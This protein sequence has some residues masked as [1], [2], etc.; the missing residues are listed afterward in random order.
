MQSLINKGMSLKIQIYGLLFLA[1]LSFFG[2]LYVSEK[3]TREYFQEQM[4]SHA[5]DAAIS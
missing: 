1:A 4:S 3:N 2:R 5:Q